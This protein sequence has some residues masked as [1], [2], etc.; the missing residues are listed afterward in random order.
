M[1][2]LE[3]LHKQF[4]CSI[5]MEIPSQPVLTRCGHLFELQA[6]NTWFLERHHCPVC[7]SQINAS[8]LVI[9]QYMMQLFAT[10]DIQ[11]LFGLTAVEEEVG[12]LCDQPSLPS[13]FIIGLVDVL[14]NAALQG[15]GHPRFRDLRASVYNLNTGLADLRMMVA[16]INK[17]MLLKLAPDVRIPV[18]AVTRKYVCDNNYGWKNLVQRLSWT[19]HFVYD[20][21]AIGPTRYVVE[22]VENRLDGTPV[23]LPYFH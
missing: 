13:G 4:L 9:S 2:Q 22:L 1:N 16:H 18:H 7:R 10:V 19:N 3:L 12:L 5:T 6:I 14:P 15:D 23:L 17:D 11:R 8:D 21:F 20:C